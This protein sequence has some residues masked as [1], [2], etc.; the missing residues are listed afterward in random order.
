MKNPK[1][2]FLNEETEG[3]LI[4]KTYQKIPI[5]PRI[6][7]G[8][9]LIYIPIL[10]TIPFVLI[11]V[12]LVRWHLWLLGARNMRSYWSFVPAWITHRYVYKT[13]ITEG[14]IFDPGHYKWFWIFNCKL[15]CPL[16]VA[17]LRYAVYLVKIVENWW[18][19]FTHERKE[20][21]CDAPID[22]SFWHTDKKLIKKLHP[23]D[24]DNPIWNRDVREKN[25]KKNSGKN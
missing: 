10:T 7:I 9:P 1:N 15:Y 5:F 17:L 22:Y 21:Y 24:R 3:V 12:T 13:Q 11:G 18:C 2:E 6:I 20:E 23:D 14:S 8:V 4:G 19:P 25:K 16:S